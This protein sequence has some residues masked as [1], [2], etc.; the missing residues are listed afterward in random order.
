MVIILC[1]GKE[2]PSE[3]G[4]EGIGHFYETWFGRPMCVVCHWNPRNESEEKSGFM[5]YY[6]PEVW[7]KHI[8]ERHSD[9]LEG[10]EF[11]KWAEKKGGH[12]WNAAKDVSANELDV[13]VKVDV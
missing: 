1:Q 8:L 10:A 4:L 5:D 12:V 6:P 2:N 7:R 9:L 13:E 11:K 3:K